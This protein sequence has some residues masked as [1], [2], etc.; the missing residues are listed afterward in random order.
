MYG[1][2]PSVSPVPPVVLP[3]GPAIG[4]VDVGNDAGEYAGNVGEDGTGGGPFFGGGGR[5]PHQGGG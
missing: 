5:L 2:S 3:G 1:R 4:V